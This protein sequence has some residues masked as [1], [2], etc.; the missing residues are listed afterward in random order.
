MPHHDDPPFKDHNEQ[1]SMID[2]TPLPGDN[3][4]WKSFNLCFAADKELPPDAPNWKKMKWDIWY[5]D[6]HELINNILQSLDFHNKFDYI[7]HQ[8]YDL[9]GNHHFHNVMSGDWWWWC[10]LGSV[11][12]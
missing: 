2:A 6:P 12:Q 4:N 7:P 8:E 5:R 1:Y 3:A 11:N 10:L 9:E